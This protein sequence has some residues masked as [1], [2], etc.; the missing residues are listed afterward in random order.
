MCLCL[1]F[2]EDVE[3]F[4]TVLEGRSAVGLVTGRRV[5][6]LDPG[7]LFV[8]IASYGKAVGE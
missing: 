8:V 4:G 1:S 6:V 3:R 7:S 5:C 2:L